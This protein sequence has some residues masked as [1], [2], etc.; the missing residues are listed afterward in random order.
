MFDLRHGLQSG[1]HSPTFRIPKFNKAFL[2][3]GEDEKSRFSRNLALQIPLC[4]IVPTLM[5]FGIPIEW[6]EAFLASQSFEG[7]PACRPFDL[8]IPVALG[9][10]TCV[11]PSNPASSA[12]QLL[13][14]LNSQLL[15]DFQPLPPSNFHLS[16][17]DLQ[18]PPGLLPIIHSS[19]RSTNLHTSYHFSWLKRPRN[20]WANN[21]VDQYV[22]DLLNVR[23]KVSNFDTLTKT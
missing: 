1:R 23:S 13:R 4:A 3:S 19:S 9:S 18:H 17:S 8:S 15:A 16:P 14:H 10:W 12:L 2:S 11:D 6:R 22:T 5:A 7:P 20:L 21:R